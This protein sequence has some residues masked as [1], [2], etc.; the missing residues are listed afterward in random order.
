[1]EDDAGQDDACAVVAG[2]V[3]KDGEVVGFAFGSRISYYRGLGVSMVEPFEIRVDGADPIPA[4]Q[5]RFG[6]GDRSWTFEEL[7]VD[8]DSRW[9]LLD[10]AVI[11][12]LVPGGLASGEHDLEVTEPLRISYLPF[13]SRTT[14]RRTVTIP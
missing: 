8:G 10:T 6:L 12:A 13:P 7:A 9:E 11:T 5:L 4:D 14:F 1:V 3:E 2:N